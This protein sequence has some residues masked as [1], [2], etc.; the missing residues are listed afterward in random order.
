MTDKV[1]WVF[2]KPGYCN[3]CPAYRTGEC[4]GKMAQKC[5]LRT[6]R[7]ARAAAVV[8]DYIDNPENVAREMCA[9]KLAG[10]LMNTPGAMKVTQD[11]EQDGHRVF[12]M[13]AMVLFYEEVTE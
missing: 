13:D 3:V 8:P 5:R 7:I 12:H 2:E 9:G 4:E 11:R 6:V 10:M 1:A